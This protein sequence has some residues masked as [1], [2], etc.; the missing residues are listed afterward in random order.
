MK[1]I[2]F[3]S[4]FILCENSVIAQNEV[5]KQILAQCDSILDK[6]VKEKDADRKTD[7]LLSFYGTSIDG[8]PLQLQHLSQELLD[9]SKKNK[10]IFIESASFS[11][12]AQAYRL[13]GNYVK[14]LEYHRKAVALAEQT[15]NKTLVGFA[16]NQMGH[17]YKD[18]LENEK[19]LALY[20]EAFKDFE[21]SG[22]NDKWYAS[23][24]LATVYYNM[25]SYDSSLFYAK[26]A[27]AK[28]TQS[29]SPGDGNQS[30]I[31]S[32]FA[33]VYSQKNEPDSV[34][35]YF[36]KAIELVNK[37]Q[38]P[39]YKNAIFVFLAEHFSRIHQYDSSAFY[40]KKA[41]NIVAGTEMDNLVL[42]P[43]KSLTAYY[44][45]INADSTVK[46]W[47]VYSVANDSVNSMRTNQQIQMLTFE[48]DQRK[49]DI[50]AAQIAY[51]N[52]IRTG[53]LLGGLAVFLIVAV[54][55]YRNNKQ[56]QKAN[57][58]LEKTL[59]ELKSTQAQLIQSEKM[60]SLGELTA[61]IAHEIQNPLNFVNNFSDVNTELI[62][63]LREELATGNLQLANE[64]AIDIK[65]NEAKINHHGKRADGIVKGMLQHSRSGT[66][67]K[68]PT[69]INKLADEYFRLSYHGIR[70]KDN[71]FNADIKN[72]F[73]ETT[74]NINVVPQDI[75]RVLLNLYNNAFYAVNEKSKLQTANYKP[76][77]SV[78][79]KRINGKIEISVTDNGNGIPQNIV[80]KIF[81]PFFT[82]KPTGS[83]TGLGLSLSYDIVKAHG[84]EIKVRS[85]EGQ[86]T[87]FIIQLPLS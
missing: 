26:Y 6:V 19:A 20:T 66:G 34:R 29:T 84:G 36:A 42:K 53:L 27:L 21:A 51:Q 9:V 50:E 62:D 48:E 28:I 11:A 25:G 44:Q 67:D 43:A 59:A 23:M 5:A 58:K 86:G 68:E 7:L 54:I 24:N 85:T 40:Y 8:F 80:D 87:E 71:D 76:Q 45:N 12:A 37:L 14:A 63:E 52:K 72:A 77:V 35:K 4:L 3:L 33:N 49:R 17:I 70:S 57:T 10:D 38:S 47:K 74:G 31:Y 79:T 64:I 65:E 55:L 18:R 61:G 46:Y 15:G 32:T 2:V 56:K 39:R 41:I 83:G 60:A 78:T 16:L 69:D 81:Q 1:K 82:T 75:G 22:K 73:D 13:T 30:I